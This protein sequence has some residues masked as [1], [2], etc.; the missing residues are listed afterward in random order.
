MA[1]NTTPTVESDVA[2]WVRLKAEIADREA[3]L[4]LIS[5]RLLAVAKDE[6]L[7]HLEGLNGERLTVVATEN[8][9]V[10]PVVFKPLVTPR[11]WKTVQ[12]IKVSV[13]RLKDLIKL[14]L[15]DRSSVAPAITTKTSVF[16][17]RG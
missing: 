10:D 6:G 9:D 3:A 4:K 13:P 16:L 2:T 8:W 17:R 5:D 15:V 14:G 11:V 12:E 7:A 1:T